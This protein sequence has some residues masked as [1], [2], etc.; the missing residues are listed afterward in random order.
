MTS[1]RSYLLSLYLKKHIKRLPVDDEV[2]QVRGMRAAMG[3]KK[4]IPKKLPNEVK[5]NEFKSDGISGEW[6]EWSGAEANKIL[7]YFH[8]GGYVS[9][10]PQTYRRLTSQIARMTKARILVVDYRLAPENRFPAAVEDGLKTYRYALEQVKDSRN[11]TIAG[12]S[13]GGGLAVATLLAAREAGLPMPKAAV[14]FSP[15]VDLAATGAS[16][17]TNDKSCAMFHGESVRLGTRIYLGAAD[18]RNPLASP[19]YAD[20]RGLPPLQIFVSTSEIFY[21]DGVRLAE[22][23][24]SDGVEVDL[25]IWKNQPHVWIYFTFLPESKKA[26]RLSAKF[27]ENA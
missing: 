19:I 11:I 7:V 3:S 21:D 9:G 14:C 25:Q 20:L 12:D 15:Y 23:A 5:I 22:K 27:I 10:S 18:P 4:L 1:I 6:V 8:G 2:R 24:K 16:L 17:V 26:L 13:A